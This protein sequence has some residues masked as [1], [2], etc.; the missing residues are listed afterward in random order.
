MR[1]ACWIAKATDARSEYAILIAFSCQQW[2]SERASMLR[3]TYGAIKNH[4]RYH[5]L[6]FA[7]LVNY[8]FLI[9]LIPLSVA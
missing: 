2:L 8:L 4:I 7:Y 9:Y 3:D 1:F 6:L 5:V